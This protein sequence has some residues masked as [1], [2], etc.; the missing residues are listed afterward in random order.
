MK[1]K[2]LIEKLQEAD[3]TGDHEVFDY[4]G[5]VMDI[6]PYPWFYD[7]KPDVVEMDS[8]GHVLSMRQINESDDK[9]IY[10]FSMNRDDVM[11]EYLHDVE[12]VSGSEEYVQK[13]AQILQVY[14]AF[15]DILKEAYPLKPLA[16]TTV[17]D[18]VTAATSSASFYKEEL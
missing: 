8:E 15:I 9:K 3:P 10:L 5:N 18:F 1:T 7:G 2:D 4:N 13:C 6:I 12:K 17:E 11:G 16:D 14:N